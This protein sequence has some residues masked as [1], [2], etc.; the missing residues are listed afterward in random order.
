MITHICCCENDPGG[1]GDEFCGGCDEQIFSFGLDWFDI[2]VDGA[3]RPYPELIPQDDILFASQTLPFLDV[4]PWWP[5]GGIA[6]GLFNPSINEI[7]ISTGDY[8]TTS[9]WFLIMY[10]NDEETNEATANCGNPFTVMVY[11]VVRYLVTI[12]PNTINVVLKLLI[13]GDRFE[14]AV[15]YGFPTEITFFSGT[16]TISSCPIDTTV[17]INNEISNRWFSGGYIDLQIA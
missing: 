7:C 8:V 6:D 4:N 15:Q 17:R 12:G 1:G 11:D 13:T 2:I 10:F 16:K 14:E 9:A 3:C 5:N